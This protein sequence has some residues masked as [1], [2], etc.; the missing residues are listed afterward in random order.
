[1]DSGKGAR[2]QPI[3]KL[4]KRLD[5]WLE[6]DGVLVLINP[7]AQVTD[8]IRWSPAAGEYVDSHGKSLGPLLEEAKELVQ[9]AYG[10]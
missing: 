1:V 10:E 7:D 6:R 2:R 9:Q 3:G 5:R 8:W 4:D